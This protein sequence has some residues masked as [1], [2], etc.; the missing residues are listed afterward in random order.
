[1]REQ[2]ELRDAAYEETDGAEEQRQEGA[3]HQEMPR[4]FR[5]PPP[6]FL[7]WFGRNNLARLTT[8]PAGDFLARQILAHLVSF[9]AKGTGERNFRAGRFLLNDLFSSRRGRGRRRREQDL[10]GV[11]FHL[12]RRQG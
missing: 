7:F 10:G 1:M 11:T 2:L 5:P 6:R 4:E 9:S 3:E 12:V 8:V